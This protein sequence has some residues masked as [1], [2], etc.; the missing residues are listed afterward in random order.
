MRPASTLRPWPRCAVRVVGARPAVTVVRR[1]WVDSVTWLR[2]T[3]VTVEVV[4]VSAV[5]EVASHHPQAVGDRGAGYRHGTADGT[6]TT[7][8]RAAQTRFRPGGC[9]APLPGER[10]SGQ[11]CEQLL[12]NAIERVEGHPQGRQRR[13]P[14]AH[15][16]TVRSVYRGDP[17]PAQPHAAGIDIQR[18]AR[19]PEGLDLVRHSESSPKRRPGVVTAA[20]TGLRS[21]QRDAPGLAVPTY[22]LLAHYGPVAP[23][24]QIGPTRGRRLATVRV[25]RRC[26][27]GHPSRW[28]AEPHALVHGGRSLVNPGAPAFILHAVSP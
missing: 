15:R 22:W 27:G 24:H 23:A 2:V 17:A 7:S 21:C 28:Q 5:E 26:A 25:R 16:R 6:R 14:V 3:C 20:L 10:V 12:D 8:S 13:L 11:T 1:A 18:R 19:H 4:L 9:P